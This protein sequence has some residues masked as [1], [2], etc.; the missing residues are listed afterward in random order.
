MQAGAPLIHPDLRSYRGF[1]SGVPEDMPNVQGYRL[2]EAGN[3]AEGF[4][5]ADVVVEH[6]F[7]TSLGHQAYLEPIAGMV[8]IGPSG[9]VEVWASN[10]VPYNL[11]DEL[12]DLIDRPKTDVVVHPT[13]E[14]ADFG[15]KGGPGDTP[16]AYYIARASG[17]PVKF[18]NSSSDDL[19]AASHR[20]PVVIQLRSGLKRN[21]TILAREGRIFFNSGA[22]GS[23]KPIRDGVLNG[24]DHAGGPYRI[25]NLH[26]EAYA[27]YTNTP[28]G[29]YMRGPGHPQVAYAVESHMDL[30]ARDIG[31]DPL[32]LRK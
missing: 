19:V 26:I 7:R 8:A 17:R 15:S 3:V 14:G 10:K 9:R 5:Q 24:S 12:A 1:Y 32:E 11:R 6:T 29:G 25:P 20:H 4:A 31:M 16:L 13:S 18:V 27:V 23:Y 2:H 22:Y 30:L 28:P 21:G